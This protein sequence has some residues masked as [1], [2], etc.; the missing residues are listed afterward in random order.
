MLA[1]INADKITVSSSDEKTGIQAISHSQT[2]PMKPGKVKRV[3]SEYKRNGTTCLIA[4]KKISTGRLNAFTLGQ[5]R[6]E[7]DYLGHIQD[8]VASE[9]EKEHIIICD[10][11]NTHKSESLVRWVAEKIEY[12][13]EL[14]IKGKTGIL[15]SQKTRMG[16]LETESHKIRFLYT[17][18][19]CS[20]MNQIENWCGIL[21]RK[22]INHGEFLSVENLEESIGKF[23]QYY[24][25]YL[26]KPIK[27]KFKGYNYNTSTY[28]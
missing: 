14:G 10:Q 26:A 17:P 6:K 8:I 11:L 20:W 16:F 19:H 12:P 27:W 1:Q 25:N 3:E 7:G 15:K 4:S 5:T 24:S 22:V 9:P 23:I 18:K 2:T 21:Q 13:Y 28:L